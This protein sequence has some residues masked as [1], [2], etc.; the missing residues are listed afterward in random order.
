[1]KEAFDENA[2]TTVTAITPAPA[3]K[4]SVFSGANPE[5]VT[6]YFGWALIGV[7]IGIRTPE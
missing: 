7:L 6:V 5:Y 1:V 4:M 3:I 2:T